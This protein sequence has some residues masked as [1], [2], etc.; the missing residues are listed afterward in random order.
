MV[1][2]VR[3]SC[4][5][6][7]SQSKHVRID[8]EV[9]EK[10]I[11]E[12]PELYARE[13]CPDWAPPDG[14]HFRDLSNPELTTQ[15]IFVLD[16]INFCFWPAEGYEYDQLAG[17]LKQVITKNP[18]AFSASNLSTLTTDTL[19]QWLQPP[20][21]FPLN[22]A[23]TTRAAK[24][25]KEDEKGSSSPKD[26]CVIPQLEERARLLREIGKVLERDFKGLAL[27]L[28]QSAKGSAER[29]VELITAHFPGF[30]DH[31]IYKGRQ[32]FLYK[33]AQIFCCDIYLAF[34]GKTVGAFTDAGKLTCFADYRLPQLMHHLGIMCYD[35]ELETKIL[36]KEPIVPG[37]E[38]ELEIRAATVVAVEMMCEQVAKQGREIFS[39]QVDN[40]LW[41][42]GE[43]LLTSLPPHHRTLT[44]YY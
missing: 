3:E 1:N 8:R 41:C 27:N 33:R 11:K 26:L 21:D 37:S 10:E 36:N 4:Q 28:V 6:A 18:S 2:G 42:R 40:L 12:N 7:V 13:A 29:L 22:S 24:R 32:I 43:S 16:A 34:K 25:V 5:W 14:S 23:L 15:Y 39:L 38:Q 20:P 44:I 19:E 30:R 31:S 17:S 9:L 35:K